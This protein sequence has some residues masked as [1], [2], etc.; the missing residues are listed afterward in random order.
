MTC[1][2]GPEPGANCTECLF[3][4]QTDPCELRNLY[5]THPAR[6]AELQALLEQYNKTV[7]PPRNKPADPRSNPKL[8]GYVWTNWMDYVS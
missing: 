7:L 3:H 1:Q 5:D 2:R 6:V 4:L 8:W